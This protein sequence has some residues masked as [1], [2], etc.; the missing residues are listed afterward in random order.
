MTIDEIQ[1]RWEAIDNE[2]AELWAGRVCADPVARE[3]E[4]LAEQDE[5]E[6]EAGLILYPRFREQQ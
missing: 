5:L 2:L 3:A 1:A 6:Y 4:L